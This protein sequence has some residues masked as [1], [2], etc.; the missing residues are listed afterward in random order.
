MTDL[1]VIAQFQDRAEALIARALLESEGLMAFVPES[2]ALGALPNLLFGEGG[3][4]VQVRTEDRV[5]ALEILRDA[6]LHPPP[7]EEGG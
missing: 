1:V 2:E 7:E 4:R 5:A 6:Q 3:Y